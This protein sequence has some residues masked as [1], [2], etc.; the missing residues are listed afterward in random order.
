MKVVLF[1][2]AAQGENTPKSDIDLFIL[3]REPKKADR[4]L[5]KEPLREKIRAIVKSPQEYSQFKKDN[6]TL[7]KEISKGV[8]LWQET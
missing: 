2:S 7:Y 3:T 1:G 6:T 5:M 8:T 4:I